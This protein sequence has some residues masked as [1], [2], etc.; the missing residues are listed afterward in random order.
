M[1]NT[2]PGT[3][4]TYTARVDCPPVPCSFRKSQGEC[5]PCDNFR[6][7]TPAGCGPYPQTRRMCPQKA[8]RGL[9]HPRSWSHCL[10]FVNFGRESP[11]F[12]Q[13]SLKNDF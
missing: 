1:G 2:H 3:T 11:T 8:L 9:S 4:H 7:P 12:P 5:P 13:K 10:A 6:E